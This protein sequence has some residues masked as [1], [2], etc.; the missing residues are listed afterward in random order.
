VFYIGSQGCH[1]RLGDIAMKHKATTK[2]KYSGKKHIAAFGA[3]ISTLAIAQAPSAHAATMNLNIS[4]GS[5]I[6]SIG[7][8]VLSTTGGSTVF[9]FVQWND[10]LGK[11]IYTGGGSGGFVIAGPSIT[12]TTGMSF[13]S[14]V[15]L[16]FTGTYTFGWKN[17]AN[18][19]GWLQMNLNGAGNPILYLGAAFNDATQGG[20]IHVGTTTPVPE[21]ATGALA[22]LGA[23]ALGATE[24]RR[25]RKNKAQTIA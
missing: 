14:G 22:A 18:Q 5:L 15:S 24:I 19:V 8:V 3:A 2:A 17:A 4:P 11:T 23:L 25:R 13:A 20:S 9:Q 12:I 6:S 1:Y 21:P 7:S 10:S 16:F